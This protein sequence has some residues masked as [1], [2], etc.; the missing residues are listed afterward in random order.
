MITL[1]QTVSNTL[2]E[3]LASH[4][5]AFDNILFVF[6]S[7]ADKEIFQDSISPK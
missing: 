7:E 1:S 4:P 6:F 5:A 2:S 3:V